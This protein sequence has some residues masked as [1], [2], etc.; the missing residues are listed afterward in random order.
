MSKPNIVFVFGEQHRA[1]TTGFGGNANV[2]TPNMD[3]MAQMGVV[4]ETAVSN[5]PVCTPWR[6][7]F[8]RDSIR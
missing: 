8:L 5:I 2:H 7:P 6:P 1:Q 3:S 4:F